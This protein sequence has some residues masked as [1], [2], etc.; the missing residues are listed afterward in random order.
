MASATVADFRFNPERVTV[1][2]GTR[3]TWHFRGPTYHNVTV[4]DGPIGF[5]SPTLGPGETFSYR[6]TRPGMYRIVCSLHPAAMVQEI[7]VH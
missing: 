3:F 7:T 1:A 2:R 4:A 5:S 6:F